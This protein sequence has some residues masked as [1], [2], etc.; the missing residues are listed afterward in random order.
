LDKVYSRIKIFSNMKK[1]TIKLNNL[2][3]LWTRPSTIQRV[4]MGKSIFWNLCQGCYV[5]F[6]TGDGNGAGYTTKEDFKKS[7]LRVASTEFSSI[8]S[9]KEHLKEYQDI[10]KIFE[11]FKK[12]S[13]EFN[14]IGLDKC[15]KEYENWINSFKRFVKIILATYV[16]EGTLDVE[17]EQLLRKEKYSRAIKAMNIIGT[18]SRLN[19]YQKMRID[20]IKSFLKGNPSLDSLRKKWGW[21]SEY[22]FIEP[23]L[24]NNYFKAEIKKLTI[25]SAKKE[26][27]KLEKHINAS[28]KQ[29]KALLPTLKNKRLKLL[30]KII[31]EY[32]FLRADRMDRMKKGQTGARA[33]FE[34]IARELTIITKR[35]WTLKMV[36][37][38]L[39]EEIL[40]FLK[41]KKIPNYRD[42]KLRTDNKYFYYSKNGKPY[43]IYDKKKIKAFLKIIAETEN[44]SGEIRGRVACA[45]KKTGT[46]AL[47]LSKKDFKKVTFQSILVAKTTMPDYTSV[48]KLAKAFVT[49]EGGITSHAATIA[50]E[51]KKP[52]IVGAKNATSLLNDGDLVE[53]DANN[54]IVK[55]LKKAK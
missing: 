46:A 6:P 28:K 42:V 17:C 53:V 20:I 54:G 33:L 15:A 48:M 14:N 21:Y 4:E 26:L 34:R 1:Q 36:A 13:F 27:E 50:R 49:E 7:V 38:F 37:N 45:G 24:D 32:T 52:C 39:N 19:D 41:N 47:V 22:S 30:A 51:L 35:K 5:S 55:V 40:S 43:L 11:L 29:W 31:H 18:P 44:Q 12:R 9:W 16:I 23:L 8:K 3:R 10:V 2:I 25:Q